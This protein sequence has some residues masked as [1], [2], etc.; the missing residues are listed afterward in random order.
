[1]GPDLHAC[2]VCVCVDR[3][4]GG[5]APRLAFPKAVSC[6]FTEVPLCPG[7][8]GCFSGD[9]VSTEWRNGEGCESQS[10]VSA[11]PQE[12]GS[13]CEVALNGQHPK[14]VLLSAGLLG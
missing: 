2:L 4:S 14:G 6:S 3:E 1:M 7:G 9:C 11:L 5:V 13:T 12:G 8:A 10:L